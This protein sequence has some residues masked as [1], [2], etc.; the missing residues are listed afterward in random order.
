MKPARTRMA[1]RRCFADGARIGDDEG[2]IEHLW[3]YGVTSLEY[4]TELSTHFNLRRKPLH[5]I[6]QILQRE[7]KREYRVTPAA[8]HEA[9]IGYRFKR[10]RPWV[11]SWL[12]AR[13]FVYEDL[14]LHYVNDFRIS[15]G[16]YRKSL[17][18]LRLNGGMGDISNGGYWRNTDIVS[19]Q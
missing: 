2:A 16:D 4:K 1:W 15:E 6:W 3:S 10:A 11:I 5:P 17:F 19:N 9:D 13:G 8:A 12:A 18:Q 14:P 7:F